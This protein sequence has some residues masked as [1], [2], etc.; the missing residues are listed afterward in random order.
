MSDKAFTMAE[1]AKH[2]DAES[3][4]WVIVEADVYDVTSK[5]FPSS[6]FFSLPFLYFGRYW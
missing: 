1:V 3:G 6:A 2:K 4:I 5:F